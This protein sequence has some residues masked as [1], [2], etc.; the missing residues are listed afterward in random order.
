MFETLDASINPEGSMDLLSRAEVAKL[1]DTSRGGLYQLF[2]GC[3]LA[4]LNSGQDDAL[5]MYDVYPDFD[6][7]VLQRDRGI[8]LILQ[9][10]PAH[11]FVDG[12]IIKGLQEHLFSVLRDIIFINN[13]L[14]ELALDLRESEGI[15]NAVF[16]ILR[17][18]GMLVTG[19]EP[20]LVVCWGGHAISRDEYDFSKE[21]GYQLGLRGLDI[22]TGCGPGVMKG[23]MKGATIAHAKQRYDQSRYIGISEPGIIAAEPPNAI[24]NHLV[25]MP[26]I[27][28]RLEGF[29]RLGHGIVIFPG[30][31]GTLEE[32]LYI[33][34]VLSHSD[35]GDLPFPV[36][37]V[38]PAGSRDYL[39]ELDR[40][41]AATLGE[42]IRNLYEIIIDDAHLIA[43]KMIRQMHKITRFRQRHRDAY[44]F[45]WRLTIPDIFQFPFEPT[46]PNMAALQLHSGLEGFQLAANLRC[47]L[48]G[49]VAGNVKKNSRDAVARLGPFNIQGDADLVA[50]LDRLLR[51]FISEGRM[52]LDGGRYTPCYTL[53]RS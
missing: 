36:F 47:A 34:G 37:L 23:S 10:A 24:V 9:N 40:F 14:G 6:I 42:G 41:L 3:S 26:D 13:K 53:S 45:N 44:Y 49:L 51:Y 31:V 2:R 39:T 20:N 8:K 28:K 33:L 30:G 18:A 25:V 27:E 11:A 43:A 5:K 12:Q 7:R 21:V 35:N 15:T 38:G 32:I 17:N 1:K 52:M 29:V 16:E 46:H 50:N 19:R 4:V 48:S 22:V